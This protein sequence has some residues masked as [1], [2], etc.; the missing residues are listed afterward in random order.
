MK[1]ILELKGVTKVFPGIKANDNISIDF[2]EGEIHTLAGENGAGKSTLMNIIFGLYTPDAGHLVVRGEKVNFKTAKDSM[3][4]KIGMVHQ[5][6]MLVP[7]LTVTQNIIVGQEIGTKFKIDIKKAEDECERLSKEFGLNIDVRDKVENLSVTEQQRVEILKVLYRKA[8]ILIFDEP[9][10]VLTPK[11]I[12]E[13]CDILLGL[14]KM[15]KTI[16]FISHKLAEVMKISDRITVIR[17]GKVIG[18]VNKTETSPTEITNMMVG[19][20]VDL[21]RK[22]RKAH[23]DATPLV[24][25]K[26]INYRNEKDILMLDDVSLTINRGEIIGVAGV[27][28]NGQHELVGSICGF[29]NPDSGDITL[30]NESLLNKNI[31]QR[32][33]FGLGYIPEDRHKDGLVLDYTI[34]ENMF[35]GLHYH[36][37]FSKNKLWVNHKFMEENALALKEAFDIRC[38][39]VNVNARTLS[40]GNQQKI[41]IARETTRNPDLLI[42]V[43]PTR[44]LDVG[45]SEFVHSAIYKQREMGKAILLV[46]FELDEI[47]AISDKIAVMYKGK[48][49]AVMDGDTVTREQLGN[50]M[51][52]GKLEE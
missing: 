1:N 24:E 51:L 29:I 47:M 42:A 27:D 34:A 6:F 46:S 28:G 50:L 43:Q 12:D 8:E 20:E 11:E 37:K 23:K 25:I 9:T 38:A 33:D 16:I 40:G 18:T 15:G 31:R 45:A 10:A 7:K 4:A 39:N 30:K 19:R 52:S 36:N 48:I 41:V 2:L 44:G 17:H 14:K 26:N 35:L 22:P 49:V 5:H 3:L 32:K 13:L 21:G